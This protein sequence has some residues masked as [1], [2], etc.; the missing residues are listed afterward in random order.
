MRR[1]AKSY[2]RYRKNCPGP[3]SESALSGHTQHQGVSAPSS[4][5]SPLTPLHGGLQKSYCSLKDNS[6][7]AH[8]FMFDR[9]R[10]MLPD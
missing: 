5:A 2:L 9:H 7:F 6:P 1:G 8:L 10:S 3:I 4:A